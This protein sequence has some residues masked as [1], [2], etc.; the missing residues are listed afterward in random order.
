M[1]A[2]RRHFFK[3][4][5]RIWGRLQTVDAVKALSPDHGVVIKQFF[6]HTQLVPGFGGPLVKVGNLVNARAVHDNFH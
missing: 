6:M 1:D 2:I 3:H 4:R 5:R